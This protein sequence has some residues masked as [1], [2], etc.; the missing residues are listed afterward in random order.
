[1]WLLEAGNKTDQVISIQT[2]VYAELHFQVSSVPSRKKSEVNTYRY[3]KT[4]LILQE[5]EA[6]A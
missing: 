5:K 4:S 6:E 1:M 3:K 2:V